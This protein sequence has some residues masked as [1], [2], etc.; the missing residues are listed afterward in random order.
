MKIKLTSKNCLLH[1]VEF[2]STNRVHTSF[3]LI[4]MEPC[5]AENLKRLKLPQ[6]AIRTHIGL[7]L[8]SKTQS[9][10]IKCHY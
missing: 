9:R 5:R 7:Y 2:L 10:I 8:L 3:D 4:F 1:N 6:S